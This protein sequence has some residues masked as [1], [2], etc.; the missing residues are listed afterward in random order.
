M[1]SK[2]TPN[3]KLPHYLP[4]DH[5]DFIGEI[6]EAY[7]IIDNAMHENASASIDLRN[8]L[9]VAENQIKELQARVEDLSRAIIG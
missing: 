9:T 7:V 2:T 1:T 8:R 5:P 4:S 6:N 3:Y